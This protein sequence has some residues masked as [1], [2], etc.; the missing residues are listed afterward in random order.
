MTESPAQGRQQAPQA[1]WVD[2][3]GRVRP[4]R[5]TDHRLRAVVAAAAELVQPFL[6]ESWCGRSLEHLAYRAVREVYPELQPGEAHLVVVA[7]MRIHA[8]A[9]QPH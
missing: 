2:A 1:I 6:E 7:S 4:E 5:R 8:R 9:A 3:L